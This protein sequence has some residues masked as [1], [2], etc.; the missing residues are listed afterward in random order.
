M[1]AA[2]KTISAENG[3]PAEV[4][5]AIETILTA[6]KTTKRRLAGELRKLIRNVVKLTA[7]GNATD[8]HR[9]HVD[10]VRKNVIDLAT[11]I[12][13]LEAGLYLWREWSK[14]KPA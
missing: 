4:I 3:K 7:L 14:V 13:A 1:E 9:E 5:P 8:E 10:L 6:F 12:A 11:K 2:Y